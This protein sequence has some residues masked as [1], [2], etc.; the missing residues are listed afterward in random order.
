M[1]RPPWGHPKQGPYKTNSK[2][3]G[4]WQYCTHSPD[5]IYKQADSCECQ[6]DVRL[7]MSGCFSELCCN[8]VP[9]LPLYRVRLREITAP[10]PMTN[11]GENNVV[12]IKATPVICQVVFHQ[13]NPVFSPSIPTN[14]AVR[15]TSPAGTAASP[16]A[17]VPTKTATPKSAIQRTSGA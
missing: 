16:A 6:Q 17:Q 3:C 1:A 8:Q 12:A 2:R 7:C 15:N 10:S 11:V 14:D 5:T 9:L 4:A 13:D